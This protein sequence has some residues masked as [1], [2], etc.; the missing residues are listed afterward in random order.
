M[1]RKLKTLRHPGIIRLL[2][3]VETDTYIYIATERV[4]PL[5][6]HVRRK[7]LSVE[8][9]KW[10]LFTVANTL[11]F[12][13]DE[14]SSV[15]GNIR[16]SSIFTSESGEWRVGGLDILSSMK[17]EAAIIYTYG[18]LTPNLSQYMPPEVSKSGWDSIKGNPT[19][20]TDSYAFGLLIFQVYNGGSLSSDQIGQTKNVPPNI[21]Q[22]Y[23]G[24]LNTNP[25]ARLSVTHFLEQGRR[26]GGFFETPLIRLSEGVESLGLKSDAER[27]ELLSELDEVSEDFPED[28][29]KMKILPE[30]LKSVEFGGGGPKV[31]GYVM[32]IGAKLTEDEYESRITPVVVRLFASPDRQM[33]KIVNDKIFPQMVTG[34]SDIAPVVREQ[35]VK[36]VLTIITKLSDRTING[37]LLKHLARTSNDEQPGIRTNTTICLGKISRNLGV[38]TRQKVLVTAFTRSLKDP[39][40]H[41]R[42]AALQ[43]LAATSDLFPEEDCANR[44]LP[45]LCQSLLDK[46]RY[47]IIKLLL[48]SVDLE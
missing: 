13:N 8:T 20:A 33:R 43:A 17:D 25:K 26:N 34:F 4:I 7:S 6:W 36:A 15:H 29:F 31:F 10:G 3:A 44:L 38:N 1:V 16:I 5:A 2:D 24:L 27:A 28:F 39:F 32:K 46:E 40:V 18:T 42:N 41:A 21:H 23:K 19:S 47:D 22:S 11:R 9:S 35:T 37:D 14:A 48:S 45:A 12:I 30:L